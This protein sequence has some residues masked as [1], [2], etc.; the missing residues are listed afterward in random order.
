MQLKPTQG[1]NS[2]TLEYSGNGGKTWHKNPPNVKAYTHPSG[3]YVHPVM[4][5]IV[6]TSQP[7]PGVLTRKQMIAEMRASGPQQGTLTTTVKTKPPVK[8]KT[9]GIV[10]PEIFGQ[11]NSIPSKFSSGKG[12]A[13]HTGSGKNRAAVAMTTGWTKQD[14][15][16]PSG[17]H[18]KSILLHQAMEPA[19]CLLARLPVPGFMSSLGTALA[20]TVDTYTLEWSRA[21]E[22]PVN[23][24]SR[25][26]NKGGWTPIQ[27]DLTI[28]PLILLRDPVVSHITRSLYPEPTG[29]AEATYNMDC[30]FEGVNNGSDASD[31]IF[32]PGLDHQLPISHFTFREGDWR[33]YGDSCPAGQVGDRRV[34]W[35][36]ASDV[37]SS[38]T[39]FSFTP[40]DPG[41]TSYTIDK[42]KELLRV[43][44]YKHTAED[45]K[46]P[47]GSWKPTHTGENDW[48][49]RFQAD[50]LSSGYYSFEILGLN[51]AETG[52]DH[53]DN[54]PIGMDFV[55]AHCTT[56]SLTCFHHVMAPSVQNKQEIIK[57]ARV[58]GSSVLVQN[59]AAE[60]ARG[61]TVYAVQATGERPWYNQLSGVR[62]ISV[63][64]LTERYVGDWAK[65]IY[66]YVKPQG[67]TPNSLDTVWE[68]AESNVT[69]VG[70]MP[71]FRPF[72]NL[73]YVIIQI[74]PP[75]AQPSAGYT[76]STATIHVVRALEFVTLDQFF[77]VEPANIHPAVYD[78]FAYS[79]SHAKQFYENPL[80]MAAL[81]SYIRGAAGVATRVGAGIKTAMAVAE[82]VRK[83]LEE[84]K[85]RR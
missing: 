39:E 30:V 52:G 12:G 8:T 35:L 51:R 42:L 29:N 20:K 11:P 61:G 17:G 83:A 10:N 57:Q 23:Q 79:L 53:W 38:V 67:V 14:F 26:S 6:P 25:L 65:G 63:A 1:T 15:N 27:D 62:D 5:R 36:D 41:Q 28:E 21:Q 54:G 71:M 77:D 24:S 19:T 78:E 31:A 64:N 73:G 40:T 37:N 16:G 48:P 68:S 82:I 18:A 33:P 70:F 66:A 58:N 59:T 7:V 84:A 43:V 13:M 72:R 9:Q 3:S 47:V 76:A 85:K 81:M 2:G 80:H 34:I 69:S 4:S 74:A 49:L 75:T 45:L 60:L 32:G 22:I 56:Y 44:L 50:I 46:E 55:S